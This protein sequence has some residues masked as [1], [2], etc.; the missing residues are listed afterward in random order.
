ML[1]PSPFTF[2]FLAPAGFG[3]QSL[4][5]QAAVISPAA[6]NGI[7]AATDAHEIVFL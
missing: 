2:A 6:A 3:G 7:F 1:P 5:I 4:M